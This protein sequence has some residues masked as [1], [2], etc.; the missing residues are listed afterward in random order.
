M[1][2]PEEELEELRQA[3]REHSSNPILL[4]MVGPSVEEQAEA[5]D[6]LDRQD[7]ISPACNWGKQDLL[8]LAER[9][10]RE[11]WHEIGAIQAIYEERYC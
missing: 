7:H 2:S 9:A 4:R 11:R 3:V 8:T 10:A 6:R 1:K 5:K